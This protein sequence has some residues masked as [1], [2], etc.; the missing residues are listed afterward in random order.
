LP[1]AVEF[2][3]RDLES[4][5]APDHRRIARGPAEEHADPPRSPALLS[6]RGQRPSR[7][8]ATNQRDEIAALQRTLN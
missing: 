2:P 8:R 3:E 1:D 7:R 5:K 4:G 6:T